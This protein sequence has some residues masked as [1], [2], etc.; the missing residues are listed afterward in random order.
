MVVA[1]TLVG[2]TFAA[3]S[4]SVRAFHQVVV[5]C[6]VLVAAGGVAGALGIIN[7]R[8]AVEAQRCP[9]GQLVGTPQ[10]AVS[11]S[12]GGVTVSKEPMPQ[13]V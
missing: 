12:N 4:E 6:A 10:P 8:R 1:S 3:N 11:Q 2:D 7:P 13:E 5:I 9:G